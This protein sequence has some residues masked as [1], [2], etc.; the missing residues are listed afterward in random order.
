MI[1][2]KGKIEI[3]ASASCHG[4]KGQNSTEGQLLQG[5]F[6]AGAG[7]KSVGHG[8]LKNTVANLNASERCNYGNLRIL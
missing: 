1:M 5:I 2:T 8:N 7:F 6:Y 4:R 3:D